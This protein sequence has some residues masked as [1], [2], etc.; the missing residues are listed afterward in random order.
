M[1]LVF[2]NAQI[3]N[4]IQGTGTS[5]RRRARAAT[6]IPGALAINY[7]AGSTIDGIVLAL[8]DRLL[9]KNQA[10]QSQNGLYVITAGTPTR[11]IDFDTNNSVGGAVVYVSE[12]T[13]N[14]S[15]GW[16]CT[17]VPPADIIGSDP[18]TFALISGNVSGTTSTDTAIVRWNGN[19]GNRVQDSAIL[20]DGGN[21]I[22]GLQYMQFN[23]IAAPTNPSN[24]QGRLFKKTGSAGIWWTPDS[25]GTSVDLTAAASGGGVTSFSAGVT[26]F[27]PSVSTTGAITLSGTL[28][29][30]SGGTGTATAPTVNQIMIGTNSGTY[31]PASLLGTTNQITVT[32]DRKS[33]V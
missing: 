7:G 18:I 10:T 6:T 29:V 30:A 14:A 11:D 32:P 24:G 31:T 12:G 15:T 26:G 19:T 27:T 8:D 13:V 20:I 28:G 23:D 3:T 22:T 16:L 4:R 9:I 21:N 17:S 5:D 1:S 25:S 2:A 33:V